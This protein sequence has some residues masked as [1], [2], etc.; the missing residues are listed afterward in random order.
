MAVLW[1]QRELVEALD[2]LSKDERKV[3]KSLL[4]LH[5]LGDGE[6]WTFESE[7]LNYILKKHGKLDSD[8]DFI[9]DYK[10]VLNSCIKDGFIEARDNEKFLDPSIVDKKSVENSS[11]RFIQV[12]C[13]KGS[14]ILNSWYF[15]FKYVG[16]ELPPLA[17]IFV[18]IIVAVLSAVLTSGAVWFFLWKIVSAKLGL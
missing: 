11:E 9:I 8:V 17:S 1:Q 7:L 10:K 14:E 18:S 6:Y 3:I 15:W 4:N 5:I 16:A 13:D 2:T 12:S